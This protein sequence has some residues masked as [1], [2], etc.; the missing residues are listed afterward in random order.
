MSKTFL[1][2]I[3]QKT[4]MGELEIIT[5]NHSRFVSNCNSSLLGYRGERDY[6]EKQQ[7]YLIVL[8]EHCNQQTMPMLKVLRCVGGGGTKGRV[9]KERKW[10]QVSN[11][12]GKA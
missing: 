6:R 10:G 3:H 8:L 11:P 5:D 9:I 2:E 4:Q 7:A 1:F 12:Q